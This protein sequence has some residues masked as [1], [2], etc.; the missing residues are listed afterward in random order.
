MLQSNSLGQVFSFRSIVRTR[1]EM[2]RPSFPKKISSC[3]QMTKF[4]S[5]RTYSRQKNNSNALS[6][7]GGYGVATFDWDNFGVWIP[8]FPIN[9]LTISQGNNESTKMNGKFIQEDKS[10]SVTMILPREYI[11]DKEVALKSGVHQ[12]F[13][14]KGDS[15]LYSSF[16]TAKFIAK[17]P[18][19]SSLTV[20]QYL[21]TKKQQF[22]STF[23]HGVVSQLEL[24]PSITRHFREKKI[25]FS[26]LL[27]DERNKR[28]YADFPYGQLIIVLK[29][30]GGFWPIAP[31]TTLARTSVIS[32]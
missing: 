15:L 22:F 32:S 20:A 16:F 28:E 26:M 11:E 5:V 10:T 25:P 8:L 6:T 24:A 21:A 17:S 14:K 31:Q 1:I 12:F 23:R 3:F 19:N 29:T 18:E 13:K 4:F 2:A 30:R 27:L 9:G 7:F